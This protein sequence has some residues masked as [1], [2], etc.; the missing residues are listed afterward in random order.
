MRN[1]E[2]YRDPTA[3][4]AMIDKKPVKPTKKKPAKKVKQEKK[5]DNQK[6]TVYY[7]TPVYTSK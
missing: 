6:K 7:I 3:G 4:A 5:N 1:L 2:G